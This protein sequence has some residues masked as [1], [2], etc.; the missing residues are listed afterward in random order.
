MGVTKTRQRK[1]K[2]RPVQE[3][4]RSELQA[5][6]LRR[7][8][9]HH[10][11][12]QWAAR[13]RPRR[14]RSGASVAETAHS[15]RMRRL[16]PGLG[17]YPWAH[18]RGGGLGLSV[19]TPCRQTCTDAPTP[20]R[21]TCERLGPLRR[22]F[23]SPLTWFPYHHAQGGRSGK[24]QPSPRDMGRAAQSR[25]VSGRSGAVASPCARRAAL[26]AGRPSGGPDGH[27]VDCGN[28]G[29]ARRGANLTGSAN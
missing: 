29:G 11:D 23:F 25:S 21:Q 1:N 6:D 12:R 18:G 19:P 4:K 10:A 24:G 17:R 28:P 7:S 14:R 16:R 2:Y 26:A 9:S 22:G 20:R 13:Q 8:A 5:P 3:K 15:R 27:R